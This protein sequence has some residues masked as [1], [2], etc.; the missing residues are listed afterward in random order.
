LRHLFW[1]RLCQRSCLND[2][3]IYYHILSYFTKI[4]VLL[5]AIVI[6]LIQF[7]VYNTSIIYNEYGVVHTR[8]TAEWAQRCIDKLEGSQT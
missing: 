8:A 2:N 4:T 7:V 3:V 1:I 6:S 5:Y